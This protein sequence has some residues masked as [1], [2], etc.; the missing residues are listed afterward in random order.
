M[1]TADTASAS[2]LEDFRKKVIGHRILT[3]VFS[4]VTSAVRTPAGTEIFVIQ[5]P[6]G[7]GKTT[8]IQR[9][10]SQIW[11]DGKE[12][13]ARNPGLMPCVHVEVPCPDANKFSWRDLYIRTLEALQEPQIEKKKRSMEPDGTPF[14]GLSSV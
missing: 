11:E 5:G 8:L 3:E 14:P 6:T 2:K 4:V 10:V 13:V 7:V 1:H 12:D 9:L